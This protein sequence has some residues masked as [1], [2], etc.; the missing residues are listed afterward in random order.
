MASPNTLKREQEDFVEALQRSH[1]ARFNPRPTT[2]R[3]R[4]LRGKAR[5]RARKNANRQ[6]NQTDA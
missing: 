6:E 1:R 2:A 3:D 5:R 4:S